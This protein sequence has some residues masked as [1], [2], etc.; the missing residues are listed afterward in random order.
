VELL[1]AANPDPD[2]RLPYLLW[3]PLGDGLV[4]RTAGTWPRTQ[5]LF[6]YPVSVDEWPAEPELVER[7]P[8]RS[9][10]R[11]GAAIDVIAARGRENR[12]QLVYTTARGREV[13][14]WQS[15]KSRKQSRPGVRTPSA[16]AAG[17]AELE[18]VVD[19]HERYPY[20]FSDKPVHT[21]RRGLPCGDYGIIHA[22][23]LAAAVERKSLADLT[24]SVTGGTVKYQLTELASLPWAAVVVEERYSEIFTGTHARPA[25]VADG[26]AELQIAFPAVP[27]VFCQTRKLAAEYTYRYLAAARAWA[28]DNSDTVE[29]FGPELT[30]T[31]AP[32]GG[33]PTTAEVRAWARQAGHSVSDRGKLRPEIWQ[34]WHEAHEQQ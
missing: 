8:L 20:T 16:R 23:R 4:F 32:S 26:L 30:L 5:A 10:R 25:T 29:A 22:G 7:V 1:V 3:V 9:C 31:T 12:S 17:I 11:R 24:S 21:T 14:F 19:A 28:T 6:C 33:Q 34:A 18:I 27:I 15:P 2:S 13:I